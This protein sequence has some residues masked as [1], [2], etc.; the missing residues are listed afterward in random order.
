MKEVDPL[1][2]WA[3]DCGGGQCVEI[4][5]VFV[6]CHMSTREKLVHIIK[7]SLRGTEE[8]LQKKR[9]FSSLIGTFQKVFSSVTVVT[10][11]KCST[12][13]GRLQGCKCVL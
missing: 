5:S 13:A 3:N 9:D 7:G 4:E 12:H 2:V 11:Q 1:F 8:P 6:L 10:K